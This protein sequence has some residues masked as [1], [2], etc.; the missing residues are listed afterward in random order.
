MQ[1]PLRPS[2]TTQHR[3]IRRRYAIVAGFFC[4]QPSGLS[5]P[6]HESSLINFFFHVQKKIYNNKFAV[7]LIKNTHQMAWWTWLTVCRTHTQ[8]MP[9]YVTLRPG[10]ILACAAKQRGP[11]FIVSF[12]VKYGKCRFYCTYGAKKVSP[13]FRLDLRFTFAQKPNLQKR[14]GLVR[15]SNDPDPRQ[16]TDKCFASAFCLF[17]CLNTLG[18]H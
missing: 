17:V 1:L 6:H 2:S 15:L 9:G 11:I 10:L 8:S 12:S 16:Q 3:T 13:N 14:F 18:E 5:P 7:R 4:K